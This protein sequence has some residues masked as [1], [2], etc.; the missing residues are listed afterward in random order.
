VAFL[1]DT[2][3][4]LNL[5][6]FQEDLPAVLDRAWNAGVVRILIPGIDVETS[7]AAVMLAERHDHLYA[8]VGVHPGD[9]ST[10]NKDTLNILRDL[11]QHPK[12]VAIGEI[13]LDYYRD[14]SPRP[15]Q[16][17][18]LEKQLALAFELDLPVVIHN[19]ESI[20]DLWSI[21]SEWHAGLM[22]HSAR[23]AARPGVLHSFDGSLDTAQAAV[24]KGFFI[25]ISGPVTF[26]NAQERQR[27]VAGLPLRGILIETDAPFLTPHPYRGRWPNEPALVAFVAEKIAGLHGQPVEMIARETCRNADQLFDWGANS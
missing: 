26:K 11:A 24:E 17:E 1:T 15:L 2:H 5:N 22:N 16:R 18:V 10:W 6:I 12:T 19:R 21:L 25:G 13:G 27:L 14:R 8:A 4:H 7:R 20:E 9:A 23:L 3:C